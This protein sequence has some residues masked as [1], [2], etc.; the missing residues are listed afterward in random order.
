VW[1]RGIALDFEFDVPPVLLHDVPSLDTV[2]IGD[3]IVVGPVG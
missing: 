2:S 3:G 1:S